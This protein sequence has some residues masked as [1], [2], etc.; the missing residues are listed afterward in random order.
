ML[1]IED[2]VQDGRHT[3]L[4][5]GA[6]NRATAAAFEAAV[7][8]LCQQDVSALSLDVRDLTSMDSVGLRAISRAR[9]I[10]HAH[11]CSLTL[12][13]LSTLT[14]RR[15]PRL[16]RRAPRRSTGARTPA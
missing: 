7:V 5:T 9:E 4:M 6:L 13:S 10:C 1:R 15:P 2:H 14:A 8:M 11:G 16:L 3:W 12:S